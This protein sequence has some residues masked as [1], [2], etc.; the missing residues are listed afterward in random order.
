MSD[1]PSAVRRPHLLVLTSTFPRWANDT[2]PRFVLD[3]CKNLL[4]S[5]RVTVLAPRCAGASREEV[6]EGVSVWRY[7][8]MFRMFETLA[9]EGGIMPK[10]RVQPLYWLLVPWL[11]VGQVIAI[12]SCLRRR[13]VDAIHA[14]WLIPQGLCAVLAAAISGRRVPIIC[15]VH[16]SD[17]LALT[18]PPFRMVQRFVGSRCA[19]IG[20]VSQPVK[21]AL[22]SSGLE[23]ARIAVLPMGV[24]VEK[25]PR[26][27]V[28]KDEF[29]IGFAGR[30]I[31]QKG[32]PTLLKAFKIVLATLPGAEL[33]IAGDGPDRARYEGL[34]AELGISKQVR[35]IGSVSQREVMEL[36]AQSQI[37]AVPSE[38]AEGLGLVALEAMAA[39]CPVVASDL[40]AF[41]TFIEDQRT[42]V[43]FPMGQA[44]GLANALVRLAGQP[45]LRESLA[46]AGHDLVAEKYG[47]TTAAT[48]YRLA[49]HEVLAG[50]GP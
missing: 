35:F 17:V 7:R 1:L 16:G 30:L 42:G 28:A 45:A 31:D 39:G 43:L 4:A 47:W 41:R 11:L 3:L 27:V 44:D 40:P 25:R 20:A 29:R 32:L 37:V 33:W 26:R 24:T 48:R 36:F 38:G 2:E 21:E 12:L 46:A 14:H 18:A 34:A 49:L 8:Y 5:H 50:E 15:T 10:L 22:I 13:D 23:T 9:Y 6:L 19:R